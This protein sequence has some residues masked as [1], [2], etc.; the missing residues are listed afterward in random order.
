MPGP[1]SYPG[2]MLYNIDEFP[3][4]DVVVITHDHYDHLDYG[5]I[6]KLKEKTKIFCVGL[7]VGEHLEAWGVKPEQIH[8]FDW[9]KVRKFLKEL[10]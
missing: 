9:W 3:D 2:T 8:E 1:K 10:S 5:T 4:L 7:G 6:Q